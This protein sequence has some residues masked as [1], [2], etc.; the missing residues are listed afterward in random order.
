MGLLAIA[1]FLSLAMAAA[2]RI[3]ETSRRSGRIDA[4]WSFAAGAACLAAV[5]L[6]AN[7]FAR[8]AIGA[9]YLAIWSVRLG[10]YLWKR[11]EHGED[12]RYAALKSE[13]G[14]K[15]SARMFGFLQIQAIAAW[16]LALSTY[17]AAASPRPSPD[18][19]DVLAALVFVVALVGEALADLEM[20][21][22][23][24]NPGNKGRICETGL[25]GWSRH[26]NY[27]FEWF[28]WLGW[29]LMAVDAGYAPGWLALLAPAWM[30]YLLVHVSG[31]PPLEQ[32][33]RRSRGASFDDYARRVNAFWLWPPAS[34]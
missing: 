19:R 20:A 6:G 33:M 22:F 3:G 29:P 28:G 7:G 26:P 11:A 8:A 24:A 18:L 14:E 4:I 25:W 5:A 30:Y 15:A 34:R 1:V 31:L 9:A 27:F 13:W 16:P 2:W 10:A 32:S 12:P 17:V 23:K 21:A